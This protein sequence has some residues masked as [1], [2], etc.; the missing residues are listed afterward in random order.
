MDVVGKGYG[1]SSRY[2]WGYG[3]CWKRLWHKSKI[4][5]DFWMVL[6]N[7]KS[8]NS[9]EKETNPEPIAKSSS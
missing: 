1:I 7:A 4:L 6:E 2:E 8:K 9:V 5:I 3:Y